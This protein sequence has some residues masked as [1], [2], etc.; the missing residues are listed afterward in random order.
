M[1]KIFIFMAVLLFAFSLMSCA[2]ITIS[3]CIK[4]YK[5]D[6][7]KVSS[8]YT[9]CITQTPEKT[10]PIHMKHQELYE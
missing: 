6:G 2:P 3:K 7:D 1:K 5:Y 8:E 9:E 10:P 4:D